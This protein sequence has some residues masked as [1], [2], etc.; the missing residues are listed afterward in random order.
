MRYAA[1]LILVFVLVFAACEKGKQEVQAGQDMTRSDT[2][3]ARA[4]PDRITVQHIL[5]AFQGSIPKPEVTRTREE[6]ESLAREIYNR[7]L[8]GEDFDSLVRQY[9]DD[10][11]PGIYK[12]ANTDVVPLTGEE[13]YS[14]SQMVK[15]FGDVGFSLPVDGIGLAVYDPETSKYGWHII[16][17]LL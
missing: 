1:L 17:R 6:A 4:E 5:I 11:H 2:E 10:V 15:A 3:Q 7:A 12:M 8:S 16:K 9:T 13:E 14:R